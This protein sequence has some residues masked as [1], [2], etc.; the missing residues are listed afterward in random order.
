MD[1]TRITVAQG[2]HVVTRD[3]NAVLAT[4]LG[5]CVAACLHDA[6]AG[7]GGMNHFLLP[8]PPEG[9]SDDASALRRY[10]AFAMELLINGMITRGAQRHRLRAHLYGGANLHAGMTRIGQENAMFARR[11]LVDEGIALIREDLGGSSARRIEFRAA[12]GLVRTRLISSAP[13]ERAATPAHG[14]GDVDLF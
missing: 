6:D 10:G 13:I 7:I 8:T 11:F 1:E 14:S 4:V 2:D 9:A 12:S 5:S 3:P